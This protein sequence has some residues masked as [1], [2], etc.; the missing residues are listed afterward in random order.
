MRACDDPNYGGFCQNFGVGNYDDFLI[1]ND[2]ISSLKVPQGLV[3]TLYQDSQSGGNRRVITQDTPYVGSDW[4]DQ[5]S[6]ISVQ[7]QIL[8]NCYTS[9]GR[10]RGAVN[11]NSVSAAA[12]VCN[13]SIAGCGTNGGCRASG[14][15]DIV[16]ERVDGCSVPDWLNNSTS[17]AYKEYFRSACNAHDECYHAPWDRIGGD[18]FAKCNDNFWHDMMNF[19]D[20]NLWAVGCPIVASVWADAMNNDPGRTQ[21]KTRF[22]QDQ[23]W[24]QSHCSD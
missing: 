8:W 5:T 18:G 7:T 4:D 13:Q 21:F 16:K 9:D 23:Q 3:V 10:Y 24:A 1:S 15:C 20:S 6:S 17:T 22:G 2:A 12:A 11:A 19:C 14:G